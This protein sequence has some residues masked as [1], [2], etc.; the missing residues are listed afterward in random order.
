MDDTTTINAMQNKQ[1]VWKIGTHWGKYGPSNFDLFLNSQ[2]AFF[3]LDDVERIGDWRSAKIGDLLLVCDGSKPVAIGIMQSK[4]ENYQQGSIRFCKSDEDEWIDGSDNIRICKARFCLIPE[5]E[6]TASWGND[7]EKRFCAHSN[8]DIVINKWREYEIREKL[9]SNKELISLTYAELAYA[10]ETKILTIPA[11]QRGVVWSPLQVINLW[12]SIVK[13]YPI[14]S[15]MLYHDGKTWCLFDGQQRVIAL[16]YG[17]FPKDI[18]IWCR[19]NND[20]IQFMATTRR[21]PWGFKWHEKDGH[22]ELSVLKWNE[23]EEAFKLMYPDATDSYSELNIESGYPYAHDGNPY[24]PLQHLLEVNTSEEAYNKWIAELKGI[25]IKEYAKTNRETFDNLF[26]DTR[27]EKIR[28]GVKQV[29]LVII[30]KETFNDNKN[31]ALR[32][33]FYRINKGGTPLSK[34]DDLYSELCVRC[35][36]IKPE[37]EKLCGNANTQFLP[38]SRLCIVAARMAMSESQ[39]YPQ[40]KNLNGVL[41][42]IENPSQKTCF[43]QFVLTQQRTETTKDRVP[44]SKALERLNNALDSS[45]VRTYKYILLRDGNDSWFFVMTYLLCNIASDSLEDDNKHIPLLA[46]LP[47]LTCCTNSPTDRNRYAQA[48]YNG[49]SLL[50]GE[51]PSLIKAIAVGYLHTALNWQHLVYP[52]DVDFKACDY[53]RCFPKEAYGTWADMFKKSWGTA[54]NFALYLYQSKYL[55]NLLGSYFNP[56]SSI[57]W[58]D[59][60]RPWDMD[61]I[62]PFEWW[63]DQEQN[64]RDTYRDFFSNIQALHFHDNRSKSNKRSGVPDHIHVSSIDNRLGN[65]FNNLTKDEISTQGCMLLEDRKIDIVQKVLQETSFFDLIDGIENLTNETC[66]V[67]RARQRFELFCMIRDKLKAEYTVTFGRTAYERNIRNTGITANEMKSMLLP[68]SNFCFYTSLVPWLAVGVCD[69]N[70]MYGIQC[71]CEGNDAHGFHIQFG[72]MRAPNI[73]SEKWM[74]E[75]QTNDP[76]WKHNVIANSDNICCDNYVN[77]NHSLNELAEVFSNIIKDMRK[78]EKIDKDVLEKYK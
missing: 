58:D 50:A 66:L 29:P 60:N 39:G 23:R 12:D 71:M 67:L 40:P 41:T 55:H 77:V 63:N 34:I 74:S 56:A 52:L 36:D 69:G 30:P 53:L 5:G 70:K 2:C 6:K 17:Y 1:N 4:F 7:G 9:D 65:K 78:G 11:V 37:I 24:L 43:E 46:C 51:K 8:K 3:S 57:T 15:F 48:F 20:E 45:S 44:F 38:A 72:V 10:S 47:F 49:I 21:H 61:H 64:L 25:A 19:R 73:S 35:P 31:G 26:K 33:L 54:E 28:Q 18:R 42:Q 59:E 68:I 13:G 75:E 76:W 14:G 22:P 62:I 27:L 32:E 16:S